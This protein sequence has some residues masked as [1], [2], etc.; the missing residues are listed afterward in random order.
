MTITIITMNNN[1]INSSFLLRQ[2]I[3]PGVLTEGRYVV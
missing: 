2:E 1:E 3:E